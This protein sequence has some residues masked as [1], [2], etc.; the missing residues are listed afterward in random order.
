VVSIMRDDF[1]V[2]LPLLRGELD[3]LRDVGP[4]RVLPPFSRCLRVA[5]GVR[6][7]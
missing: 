1:A 4:H 3:E 2:G 5:W 7:E 6:A